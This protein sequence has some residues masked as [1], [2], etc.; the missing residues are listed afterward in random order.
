MPR[1]SILRLR[2]MTAWLRQGRG[3][4]RRTCG[5]PRSFVFVIEDLPSPVSLFWG[6]EASIHPP[7]VQTNKS[8]S[9]DL[10]GDL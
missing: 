8:P 2:K 9:K 1:D 5:L 6:F 7:M 4:I 3:P 10:W